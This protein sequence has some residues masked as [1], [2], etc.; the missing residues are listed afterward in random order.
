VTPVRTIE[1]HHG[2]HALLIR[3]E[4][5]GS[6]DHHVEIPMHL[7]PG[8]AATPLGPGLVELRAAGRGFRLEWEPTDAWS[9]S[10]GG[11]RVSPSYG[12]AWPCTRLSWT[13]D[14]ALEPGL[15]VR[16]YPVDASEDR[17]SVS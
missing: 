6:G 17:R 12:V 8:V 11:A 2:R 9:M 16:I 10:I 4:F 15:I 5:E 13:R 7:A 3:D 14:G 1:L